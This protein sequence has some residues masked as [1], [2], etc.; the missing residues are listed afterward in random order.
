MFID[1]IIYWYQD[2]FTEDAEALKNCRANY[3]TGIPGKQVVNRYHGE[4]SVWTH[5]M[6]ILSNMKNSPLWKDNQF[7]RELALTAL[8]H[9]IGK[10][11]SRRP[12]DEKQHVYM[13]GHAGWSFIKAIP[14]LRQFVKD[15]PQ[16]S[17]AVQNILRLI[18]WHDTAWHSGDKRMVEV[19]NR[20]YPHVELRLQYLYMM[21]FDVNG[22]FNRKPYDPNIEAMLKEMIAKGVEDY[23][24]WNRS[25]SFGR[26][27]G[28]RPQLVMM[29]GIPGAGKSTTAINDHQT[30]TDDVKIISF[31]DTLKSIDP[32]KSYEEIWHNP[33]NRAVADAMVDKKMKEAAA[34]TAG[35]VIDMTN[36][37]FKS[38]RQK[39]QMFDRDKWD[40]IQH[41][42]LCDY[43]TVMARNAAREIK[44]G[45]KGI[46]DRVIESMIVRFEMPWPCEGDI[47]TL[48]DTS[49]GME[50]DIIAINL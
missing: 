29:C 26:M 9:D 3:C 46:H 8:L 13:I 16:Y 5:T 10:I 40:I 36:L 14:V 6:M 49:N 17:L 31:D 44:L 23:A 18:S 11:E 24:A 22:N 41:T 25:L 15:H 38:R 21:Q 7:W 37:T 30:V 28:I 1:D 42:V 35:V 45:A 39:L 48:S 47:M 33:A 27:N 34:G 12:D 20:C 2:K 19:I 43:P 50:D 4:D 32:D